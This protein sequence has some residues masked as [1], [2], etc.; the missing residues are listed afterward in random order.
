MYAMLRYDE[1]YLYAMVWDVYAIVWDM[2]AML[3]YGLCVRDMFELTVHID[4]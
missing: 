4:L 1:L 2:N 3:C